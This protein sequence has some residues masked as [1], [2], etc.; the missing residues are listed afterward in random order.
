MSIRN[1]LLENLFAQ[2]QGLIKGKFAL[3]V[4]EALSPG[5]S[6]DLAINTNDKDL[7]LSDFIL[8]SNSN[9]VRVEMYEGSVFS[10]GELLQPEA[11]DRTTL[12]TFPAIT[13]NP[14][15]SD[16]GV[17]VFTSTHYDGTN[18]G[19]SRAIGS[20]GVVKFKQN[21]GYITRI[22]NQSNQPGNVEAGLAG[23]EE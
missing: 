10:G 15:V 20:A 12:E 19:F 17:L 9:D 8:N 18:S 1:D 6:F 3:T 16:L 22:T 11:I 23:Y 21:T 2:A 5:E 4:N 7:V 13:L 14:T